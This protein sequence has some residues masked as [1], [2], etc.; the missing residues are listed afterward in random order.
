M[1]P[2]KLIRHYVRAIRRLRKA[3]KQME[4]ARWQYSLAAGNMYEAA[5]SFDRAAATYRKASKLMISSQYGK[6]A[7]LN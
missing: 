5:R 6:A 2:L 4:H 7:G 3:T 1:T